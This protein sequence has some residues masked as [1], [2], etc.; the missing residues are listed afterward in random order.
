M[1][2][3]IIIWG[4]PPDTHTHS[5]IHLG[6]AKAFSEMDYDVIW[7]DDSE[8]YSDEDLRDSIIITEHNCCKFM[9]YEKSSKYFIHN[10]ENGFHKQKKFDGDNVYNLL[11]YHENYNWNDKISKV[12]DYSWYDLETKTLA[13]MWASDLLP[14]EI[15]KQSE[16]LFDPSKSTVNYIGS[17]SYDHSE[18]LVKTIV[19]NGKEFK[20]YGG[21]T[22]S[23]SKKTSSGF[24]SEE[25][26]IKLTRNSYLNFD[27]RPDCHVENG[28][29][30]CRVFKTMS[31]G[32]WIGTNSEKISKF[33]EGRITTNSDL[34]SLYYETEND[35]KNA[36]IESIRDNMNFIQKNHTYINRSQNLLSVL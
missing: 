34:D 36:T 18:D 2:K 6:F 19:E 32:C 23:R 31:Y 16:V 30:P 11:V 29:V 28:Y 7:Y 20:N 27:I 22:G 33:F 13:I 4:Y 14:D 15:E 8:E 12:D 17:L 9:P 26:S 10:I 35:S 3:K 25:E 21:Y 1:T 24:M 5:Y